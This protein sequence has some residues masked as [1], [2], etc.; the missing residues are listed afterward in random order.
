MQL[1]KNRL[2]SEYSIWT[3]SYGNGRNSDGLRFGQYLWSRYNNMYLFTDV[4]YY[5]SCESVYSILFREI[6]ELNELEEE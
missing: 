3:V 1:N 2:K 4:F 5:D 6:E